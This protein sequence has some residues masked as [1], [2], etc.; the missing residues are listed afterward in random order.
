M[1]ALKRL[2]AAHVSIGLAVGVVLA[3]EFTR[4]AQ[5]WLTGSFM[6]A[7]ASLIVIT[8]SV[9][10]VKYFVNQLFN[11]AKWFRRLMLGKQFVEGTWF[12]IMRIGDQPAVEVGVSRLS[13]HDAEVRYSGDDYDLCMSHTAPYHSEMAQMKWDG[14][15]LILMYKYRAGRSDEKQVGTE[16]YGELLFSP[17]DS[18]PNHYSGCYFVLDGGSKYSFEGFRLDERKDREIL[19]LLNR[20]DTKRE[21][22]RS[23]LQKYGTSQDRMMVDLLMQGR[24]KEEALAAV[25]SH[26]G[27]GR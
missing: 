13:Y 20:G 23:L 7:V 14:Q 22:L 16:G 4:L 5:Q 6:P 25:M 11:G 24:N 10:A 3:Q 18:L 1:D 15:R 17:P 9:M 12:D 8:L 21:A 26:F 2:Q 27:D 19:A